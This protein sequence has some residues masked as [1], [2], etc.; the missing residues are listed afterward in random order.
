MD[1]CTVIPPEELLDLYE[2]EEQAKNA[3]K[4]KNPLLPSNW[5]PWYGSGDMGT[6]PAEVPRGYN[7]AIVVQAIGLRKETGHYRK[8][9]RL[10]L[11]QD[12]TAFYVT[13]TRPEPLKPDSQPGKK[14]VQRNSKPLLI[15]FTQEEGFKLQAL[16][17]NI[18]AVVVPGKDVV[19]L[20]RSGIRGTLPSCIIPKDQKF[21]VAPNGY[22]FRDRNE[23]GTIQTHFVIPGPENAYFI[24][25]YFPGPV[26]PGLSV[27]PAPQELMHNLINFFWPNDEPQAKLRLLKSQDTLPLV[28]SMIRHH[29]RKVE[30][31]PCLLTTAFGLCKSA[32]QK[33]LTRMEADLELG[34]TIASRVRD[35]SALSQWNHMSGTCFSWNGGNQENYKMKNASYVFQITVTPV[36]NFRQSQNF[37]FPF[38]LDE[39]GNPFQNIILGHS[40]YES[41]GTFRVDMSDRHD[42]SAKDLV[43]FHITPQGVQ[44]RVMGKKLRGFLQFG[45]VYIPVTRQEN[46]KIMIPGYF[47]AHTTL[48]I[49]DSGHAYVVQMRQFTEPT[50]DIKTH[51]SLLGLSYSSSILPHGDREIKWDRF[52]QLDDPTELPDPIPC[53]PAVEEEPQEPYEFDLAW[54]PRRQDPLAPKAEP[55]VNATVIGFLDAQIRISRGI[56]NPSLAEFQERVLLEQTL[57]KVL[58]VLET[59]QDPDEFVER[60]Q[61]I[62]PTKSQPIRP[63]ASDNTAPPSAPQKVPHRE[64]IAGKMLD[65]VQR[66]VR[67]KLQPIDETEEQQLKRISKMRSKAM[68]QTPGPQLEP[69]HGQRPLSVM[70]T[71]EEYERRDTSSK[72]ITD[73]LRVQGYQPWGT[74]TYKGITWEERKLVFDTNKHFFIKSVKNIPLCL[75]SDERQR[76]ITEYSAQLTGKPDD[77]PLF[78]RPDPTAPPKCDLS[79]AC[80]QHRDEL[81]NSRQDP[82]KVGQKRKRVD[83]GD[84]GDPRKKHVLVRL[85]AY[86]QNLSDLHSVE[87][88]L[89]GEAERHKEAIISPPYNDSGPIRRAEPM[90]V[91]LPRSRPVP[92]RCLDRVSDPVQD[93][94]MEDRTVGN[95]FYKLPGDRQW[96]PEPLPRRATRSKRARGVSTL[97]EDIAAGWPDYTD[98]AWVKYDRSKKRPVAAT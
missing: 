66:A 6:D 89:D 4:I 82:T 77:P 69:M 93:G 13:D 67:S 49:S 28:Q 58:E 59:F 52:P 53:I 10:T 47:L 44:L 40:P 17:S 3:A 27:M 65:I 54:N 16:G 95:T 73:K 12:P 37:V 33:L 51:M 75:H 43:A 24:L 38:G 79:L 29:P 2:T 71:K 50:H 35:R 57:Q 22:T 63:T 70:E 96:K 36:E 23:D 11:S 14:V 60:I 78:R 97:E 39:L 9:W 41:K 30:E 5:I 87:T 56:P 84:G 80:Q 94:T 1:P 86:A 42:K 32:A 45:N 34:S 7:G 83:S 26:N 74:H 72:S 92:P 46:S 81:F 25:E 31:I 64:A 15:E 19:R 68:L 90:K 48:A 91:P 8:C 55:S 62:L 85:F 76:L 98:L 88:V 20:S 61:D 21:W 18:T